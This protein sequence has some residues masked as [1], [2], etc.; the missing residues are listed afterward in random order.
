MGQT[1]F[2][3]NFAEI[4]GGAI[5]WGTLEP[6]FGGL[7]SPNYASN[8]FRSNK[9]GRYGDNISTFPTTVAIIKESDY[10]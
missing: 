8:Q 2:T 5:H 9:A 10:K 6:I 3:S 4:K 7:T 1:A